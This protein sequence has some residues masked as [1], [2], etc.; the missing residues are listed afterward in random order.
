MLQRPERRAYGVTE[1][2]MSEEFYRDD[3]GKWRLKRSGAVATD[4]DGATIVLFDE[5]SIGQGPGSPVRLFAR[6]SPKLVDESVAE[7]AASVSALDARTTALILANQTDLADH[8]TRI[9]TLEGGGGGGG[10]SDILALTGF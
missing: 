8:E 7:V 10:G 4:P 1:D 6:A 2:Q 9:T 5:A 3:D